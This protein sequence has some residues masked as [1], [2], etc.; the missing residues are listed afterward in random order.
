MSEKLDKQKAAVLDAI[1]SVCTI[2]RAELYSTGSLV[3]GYRLV[4]TRP[5]LIDGQHLDAIDIPDNAWI[6]VGD[7]E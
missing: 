6:D 2:Q 1:L 3:L 5:I 4:M 7:N